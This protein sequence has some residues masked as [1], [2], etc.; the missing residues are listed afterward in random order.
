MLSNQLLNMLKNGCNVLAN[1]ELALK[2]R[3][4]KRNRIENGI[5]PKRS[6]LEKTLVSLSFS[7]FVLI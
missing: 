6:I 1:L 2:Y 3:I 5:I 7:L 4:K